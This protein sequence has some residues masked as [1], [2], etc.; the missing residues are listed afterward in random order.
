MEVVSRRSKNFAQSETKILLKLV[1]IH[2]G[3]LGCKQTDRNTIQ[4]KRRVWFDIEEEFNKHSKFMHT[5]WRTLKGKYK[6]N[7]LA[8]S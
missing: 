7:L 2:K 5:D 3:V 1:N 8:L 4:V 6:K